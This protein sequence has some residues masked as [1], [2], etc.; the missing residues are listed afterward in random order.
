M[1]Q[2]TAIGILFLLIILYACWDSLKFLVLAYKN[3]PPREPTVEELMEQ[4]I[5]RLEVQAHQYSNIVVGI[6]AILMSEDVRTGT[7]QDLTNDQW[8][9]GCAI[10]TNIFEAVNEYYARPVLTLTIAQEAMI[11]TA[12]HSGI[13]SDYILQDAQYKAFVQSPKLLPILN[14]LNREVV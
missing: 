9:R 6:R 5:I 14:Y 12:D 1:N 13:K 10:I 4:D 2:N 8:T 7:T 11:V 3:K